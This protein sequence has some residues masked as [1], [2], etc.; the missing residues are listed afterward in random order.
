MKIDTEDDN[1]FLE[2][3]ITLNFSHDFFFCIYKIGN[4]TKNLLDFKSLREIPLKFSYACERAKNS[5]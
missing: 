2:K 5:L 3:K 1:S 4:D